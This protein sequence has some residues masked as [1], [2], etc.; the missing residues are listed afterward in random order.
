MS[1]MLLFL[2][3]TMCP[4]VMADYPAAAPAPMAS[5][6]NENYT[7]KGA[8]YLE[9]D[10]GARFMLQKGVV[11]KAT[12]WFGTDIYGN[13]AIHWMIGDRVSINRTGGY[14]FP[15]QI[16]NLETNEEAFGVLVNPDMQS[17][18][19]IILKL[20][21]VLKSHHQLTSKIDSL[22]ADI[23]DIKTELDLVLD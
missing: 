21:E 8:F 20:D 6:I 12:S 3:L 7:Y 23:A 1:K 11:Q 15:F 4:I 16:V 14:E 19:D 10:N 9:L 17:L 2:M 22:R 5:K 13:P 18:E